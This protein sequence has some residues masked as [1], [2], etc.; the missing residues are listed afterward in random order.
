MGCVH[1][2]TRHIC[3]D[4]SAAYSNPTSNYYKVA[5]QILSLFRKSLKPSSVSA[6]GIDLQEFEHTEIFIFFSLPGF[7]DC[8]SKPA[9]DLQL[10]NTRGPDHTALQGPRSDVTRVH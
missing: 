8:N 10:H 5:V 4:R 2:S 6:S 1:I 9:D 3:D 7:C